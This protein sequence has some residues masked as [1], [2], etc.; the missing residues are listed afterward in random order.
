MKLYLAGPMFTPAERAYIDALADRL[1]TVGHGCFVPHRQQF[2]ALDAATIFAVDGAGLRGA[3][4][5]VAWLD[6][7]MVDDGT[8]CEVGIF[9][10]PVCTDPDQHRGI[11]GLATDRR[12]WRSR[13]SGAAG[14]GVNFFVGDAIGAFGTIVWSI[15]DV[16]A[17]L[18][19]W[20]D[21][22]TA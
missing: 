8:A 17:T 6:G 7:P 20:S 13:D 19:D 3:E 21:R 14:S 12:I 10:E 18:R 22:S 5:V 1:E 9:T 16:E 4:V 2:A 15:E 11:I